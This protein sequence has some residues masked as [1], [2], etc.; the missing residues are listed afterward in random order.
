[1]SDLINID[2]INN[3]ITIKVQT[4]NLCEMTDHEIMKWI[5]YFCDTLSST[6]LRVGPVKDFLPQDDSH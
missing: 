6:Q 1:M 2:H 4:V 5:V 3:T